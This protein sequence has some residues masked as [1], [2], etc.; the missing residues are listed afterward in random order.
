MKFE[1]NRI[2]PD[3]DFLIEGLSYIGAPRSNT[4]MFI[5]KK[6][7]DLLPALRSV[8][9]CLIFAETG[10]DV[11]VD[12]ADKHAFS[13]SCKPQLDYAHF[14]NHFAEERFKEEQK[15]KM[16]LCDNGYYVTE[17]VDIPDDAYI[18][19]GCQIGPSVIIG[20]NA[21]ILKGCVIRHTTI[22]D[23]F[24]ANEYAVIGSNGFTMTDDEN[25]NKI[26][27]PTLGRV[28]IGDN[29]EVGTH[30]NISCGSGG[31]TII[32]DNVKVDA[33]VHIGHD[34]YLCKNV[35]ITAGTILGGFIRIES[36]TFVGMNS[37]V[38]NRITIGENVFISMGSAVMK[39]VD[40]NFRVVGSP[41]R[42]LPMEKEN[43]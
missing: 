3:K 34:N 24:F 19:P 9:E 2:V 42:P 13:F 31:D 32:E 37:T 10:I 18:E 27:I 14:A 28:I 7:E 1:V 25:D 20:K 15:L 39:A 38:R 4:A 33:L 41:A 17:D 29:V 26:R 21:K 5:T 35:E 6:V 22:G 43:S 40:S 36:G 23:N 11:P 8:K 30:D 12:L 16:T